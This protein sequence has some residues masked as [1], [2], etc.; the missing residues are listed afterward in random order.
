MANTGRAGRIWD[1]TLGP[2]ESLDWERQRTTPRA[3]ASQGVPG[4]MKRQV[5]CPTRT[6][7]ELP[8]QAGTS[9]QSQKDGASG[10]RSATARLVSMEGCPLATIE[11]IHAATITLK[12]GTESLIPPKQP[13]S[14][15]S[16]TG[17]QGEQPKRRW[18]SPSECRRTCQT[19][20]HEFR[21]RT[22][23]LQSQ[24]PLKPISSPSRRAEGP[25]A[26]HS[27]PGAERRLVRPRER[28]RNSFAHKI[29]QDC[30]VN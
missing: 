26:L 7:S 22:Q 12:A 16:P 19:H 6:N 21:P 27:R 1:Q 30:I 25:A 14:R 8:G 13:T 9:A 11:T 18:A 29:R 28:A 3:H 4:V 5:E 2:Q 23:G 17:H 20:S 10:H 15:R 24:S